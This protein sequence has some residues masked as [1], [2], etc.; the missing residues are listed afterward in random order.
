MRLGTGGRVIKW[1]TY[2]ILDQG[3]ASVCAIRI[4]GAGSTLT[5]AHSIS[6]RQ[7]WHRCVFP[8]I[9][10]GRAVNGGLNE[11]EGKLKEQYV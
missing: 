3:S 5:E 2:K 1:P 7:F 8:C 6:I 4:A 11:R 9:T 10:R